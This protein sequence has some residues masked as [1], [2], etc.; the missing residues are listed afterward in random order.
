M[1]RRKS[2]LPILPRLS[3][4]CTPRRACQ[5]HLR[6]PWVLSSSRWSL[7]TRTE[8]KNRGRW[9]PQEPGIM[10]GGPH[11]PSGLVFVF[12]TV[13]PRAAHSACPLLHVLH[14]QSVPSGEQQTEHTQAPRRGV[15]R[16]VPR[17]GRFCIDLAM[18]PI[19]GLLTSGAHRGLRPL[20][21]FPDAA[22][23]LCSSVTLL[24]FPRSGQPNTAI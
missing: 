21:F 19:P 3:W 8:G 15:L 24:S 17:Q 14:P 7:L 4:S 20:A 5:P 18:T 1:W 9:P 11:T 10:P 2:P 23:P 6:T 13:P 22:T 16:P 12:L